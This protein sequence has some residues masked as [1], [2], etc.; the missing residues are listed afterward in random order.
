VAGDADKDFEEDEEDDKEEHGDGEDDETIFKFVE[1]L[2][3]NF[4]DS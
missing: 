1:L 2:V 4:F 3:G